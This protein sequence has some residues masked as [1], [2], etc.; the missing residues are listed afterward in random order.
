MGSHFEKIK[1]IRNIV[2]RISSTIF[3]F[4]GALPTV[5]GMAPPTRRKKIENKVFW[6]EVFPLFGERI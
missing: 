1:S 6:N 3:A 5:F 2:D 4:S